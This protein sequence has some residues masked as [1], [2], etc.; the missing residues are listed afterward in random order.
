MQR[1][2]ST[3][4]RRALPIA[5]ALTDSVRARAAEFEREHVIERLWARDHTIW[6]PDPTEVADRLGWLDVDREMV[7]QVGDLESFAREIRE[8]GYTTAVVLGMGGS[9][10][11]P[12]VLSTA[13][14]GHTAGL[15]LL[16]LDSTVPDAI[17]AVEAR[18][19]RERTLFI[20]SSKSGTTLE[21]SALLDFF[22]AREPDGRSFIA[23]TDEGTSLQ[24]LAR[25]RGFRR[26]FVNRSDIGGRF[27]ALSFVG[28]VPAALMGID[29]SRFLDGARAMRETCERETSPLR[30]PGVSTGIRIA[31]A[32]LL[33]HDALTLR[34]APSLGA[35]GAW[36][37]QLIAEST[38]KDG[39][40]ILP[41]HDEPLGTPEAYD[42]SRFFV[43][44]GESDVQQF[45][46]SD[47][48]RLPVT[49]CAPGDAYA[50]GGEFL[51][52]E[53]AVAI[54]GRVLGINPFDQPDVE[55]TKRQ[56]SR[57]LGG[58]SLPSTSMLLGDLV[59]DLDAP[60]YIEYV[61]IHAYLVRTHAT[62]QR[63]RRVRAQLR[64]RFRLPT[65]VEYGPSLLHSTGQY[66]K[67]GRRLGGFVQ[68]VEDAEL[69]AVPGREYDFAHLV[70]A[71][72]DGDR[73]ALEERGRRVVRATIEDLET[74]ADHLDSGIRRGREVAGSRYVTG[75][76]LAMVTESSR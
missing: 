52:W 11:T 54:A 75:G 16:V 25:E 29:L 3:C 67:G 45:D 48:G 35:L 13:F 32:A 34:V 7:A 76:V 40:G 4:A 61:A 23:I 50:L 2:R 72:A 41:V 39:T 31:E 58:M 42:D 59:E 9:S 20:V 74:L 5:R 68:I 46:L 28:L 14:A 65:T 51:R 26:T 15:N 71:Q 60:G 69:L 43:T 18:A 6:Q 66:H 44:I 53:I 62:D 37:E 38:G 33:D 19:P 22:W 49:S 21:T 55:A 1:H 36:L 47:R 10:L 17:R 73:I 12:R 57:L 56:T 24:T 70:R 30:N 8:E 64:D 27:S 63:L